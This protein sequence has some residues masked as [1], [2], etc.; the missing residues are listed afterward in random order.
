MY[1]AGSYKMAFANI[2][3]K[4][5]VKEKDLRKFLKNEALAMKDNDFDVIVAFCKDDLIKNKNKTF[6][7][8]LVEHEEYAGQVDEI[9]YEVPTI[10]ILVP[11]LFGMFDAVS[12]DTESQELF[13]ATADEKDIPVLYDGEEVIRL[14]SNEMP[15]EPTLL[16]KRTKELS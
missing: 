7:E 6:K 1:L 8:V 11:S 15:G 4:A 2:L 13:V 14:S 12:W 10:T 3:S 9:I 16:S 5:V